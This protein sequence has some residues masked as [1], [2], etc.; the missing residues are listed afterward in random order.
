M[1]GPSL[2]QSKQKRSPSRRL[3]PDSPKSSPEK[4]SFNDFVPAPRKN[5]FFKASENKKER[6]HFSLS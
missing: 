2:K 5:A 1:V 4:N 3:S 6:C